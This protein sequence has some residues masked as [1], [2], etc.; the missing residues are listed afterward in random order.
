M[1]DSD[2]IVALRERVIKLENLLGHLIDNWS[3]FGHLIDNEK[4]IIDN[5]KLTSRD[6]AVIRSYVTGNEPPE[7]AFDDADLYARAVVDRR[8]RAKVKKPSRTERL[9]NSVKDISERQANLQTEFQTFNFEKTSEIKT[10]SESSS[11][12][13]RDMRLW[14]SVQSLGLDTSLLSL[15]RYFPIRIFLEESPSPAVQG[16]RDEITKLLDAF[17]AEV[18]DEFPP[19][20]GSFFQTFTGR[21]KNALRSK[22]AKERYAKIEKALELQVLGK[23][24]AD[25]NLKAS[26]AF[27]NVARAL[28]NSGNASIQIGSMIYEQVVDESGRHVRSRELTLAEMIEIENRDKLKAAVTVDAKFDFKQ[29]PE[30]RELPA[31]DRSSQ[32]GSP[33]R[34]RLRAPEK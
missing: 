2:E 9:E 23:I 29:L 33:E 22:E 1:A 15:P 30:V 12:T 31:P 26:E 20:I 3:S 28:E 8:V 11:Q 19:V 24:Q 13:G 14:F 17:G 5:E 34:L 25:I 4:L 21:F 16:L 6:R 10:L 18:A 27:A 32:P 7:E